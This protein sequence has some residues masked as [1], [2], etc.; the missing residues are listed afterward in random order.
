MNHALLRRENRS[1]RSS[2]PRL[3]R[4]IVFSSTSGIEAHPQAAFLFYQM[5]SIEGFILAGGKSSRMGTDK[6]QLTIRGLSFIDQIAGELSPIAERVRLVG[7]PPPSS[8]L[9][10]IPDVYPKWGALGGVH[11]AIASCS[12]EWAIVVACDFPLVTSELFSSLASLR[13]DSDAVAPVQADKIPQP[14]CALYRVEPCLAQAESLIKTGERKPIAL[15]QSVRT[16][17]VAFNEIAI[18]KGAAHFFDNI[19]TPEDY[20]RL[21]RKEVTE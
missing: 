15:L 1:K 2:C 16:R 12:A 18:L 8:K 4:V 20:E 7:H 19:N 21:V 5:D 13:G 11:A 6:S 10:A 9:P 17:W 14:L 3:S